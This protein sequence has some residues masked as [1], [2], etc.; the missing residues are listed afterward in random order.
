ME[1]GGAMHCDYP[2]RYAI[3]VIGV[4]AMLGGLTPTRVWAAKH[5]LPVPRIT[6]YPGDVITAGAL[7][8]RVFGR[9]VERLPVIRSADAA[10]GKVARRTLLPKRPIPLNALRKPNVIQ[11][12]KSVK[13]VF[14]SG[15]LTI[16]TVGVALQS[17]HVGDRLNVRN[18]ESGTTIRGVAQADGSI[19]V[20]GP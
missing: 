3:F 11:Q 10:I 19:R 4:L 13:I 8:T 16:T 12:G 14:Q 5:K 15:G 7:G 6:I 9:S 20:E 17:G 18:T 2:S 1:E